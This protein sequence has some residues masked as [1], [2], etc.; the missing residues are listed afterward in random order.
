MNEGNRVGTY[1]RR[2]EADR[3]LY[4]TSENKEEEEDEEDPIDRNS[5][6]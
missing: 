2:R 4:I 1:V 6:D 5:C 3:V